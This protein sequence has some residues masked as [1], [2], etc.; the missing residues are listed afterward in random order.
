MYW[1]LE[2][3]YTI[4]SNVWGFCRK[5]LLIEW[6]EFYFNNWFTKKKLVKKISFWIEKVLCIMKS[7]KTSHD[8]GE[9]GGEGEKTLTHLL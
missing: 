6:G 5:K 8:D 9:V 7:K 3:M 4:P 1:L 2:I